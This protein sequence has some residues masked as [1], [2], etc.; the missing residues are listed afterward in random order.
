MAAPE[1]G[2]VTLDE[3][4]ENCPV[5]EA[6]FGRAVEFV[7]RGRGFGIRSVVQ[8]LQ[9][10][11]VGGDDG[12]DQR[13]S[14]RER[15]NGAV[16]IMCLLYDVRFT[17]RCQ[18][19]RHEFQANWAP[20]L[21]QHTSRLPLRVGTCPSH[22]ITWMCCCSSM[23]DTRVRCPAVPSSRF[24]SSRWRRRSCPWQWPNSPACGQ[25]LIPNTW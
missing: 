2:W 17:R 24:G 11:G 9:R 15:T 6:G 14:V 18:R 12:S 23:E 13:G 4:G 7:A 8:P 3:R 5:G 25:P 20:C 22:S 10:G 21:P 1:A 19:Q 16:A